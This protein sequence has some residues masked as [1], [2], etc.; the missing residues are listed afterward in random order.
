[1]QHFAKV[2]RIR[3]TFLS[4]DVHC[5]AI[6]L[7]KTL[8]TKGTPEVQ[9]PADFRYMANVVTSAYYPLPTYRYRYALRKCVRVE[10]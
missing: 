3:V 2:K 9:P 5:A 10:C 6:G 4:G 8:R 7:L 1:M